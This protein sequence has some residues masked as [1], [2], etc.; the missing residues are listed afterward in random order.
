MVGYTILLGRWVTE[1]C[2]VEV[3]VG[4]AVGLVV[5]VGVSVTVTLGVTVLEGVAVVVLT[6]LVGPITRT[7]VEVGVCG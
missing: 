1:G 7:V 6:A 4:L 5:F 2:K 3:S